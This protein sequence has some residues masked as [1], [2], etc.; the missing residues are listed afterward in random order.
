[1]GVP[2]VDC[3]E[4]SRILGLKVILTEIVAY[5]D[6]GDLITNRQQG[7]LPALSSVSRRNLTHWPLGDIVAILKYHFQLHH[8][9]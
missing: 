3:G 5:K 8:T 6:L 9:E 1:M 7:I 2:I 4:V